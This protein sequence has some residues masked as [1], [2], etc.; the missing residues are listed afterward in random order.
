MKRIEIDCNIVE[1]EVPTTNTPTNATMRENVASPVEIKVIKKTPGQKSPRKALLIGGLCLLVLAIGGAAAYYF[2]YI[3]PSQ[4]RVLLST[5]VGAKSPSLF[6]FQALN[7]PSAT[8]PRDKEN[9]IN[10]ELYTAKQMNSMKSRFP[11]AVMIENHFAA[12]PQSCYNKADLVYETLA[13]GGITR[14]MAFFWGHKCDKIG[15]VRSARQYFIE[16]LMPFDPL[17]MHIGYAATTDPR[18][19]AGGSLHTYNI[20]TL[21]KGG[22]F[23]RDHSRYAP[24][25]AYTSTDLLYKMA[26][27]YGY[28]GKP[29]EIT[30]W[31]FKRDLPIDQRG[32]GPNVSM[33]FYDRLR[34]GGIYDISWKYDRTKNIYYRYN[35][36]TPYLDASTGEK[37]YAHNLIIERVKMVP[38]YDNHA[39]VIITTTGQGN[40]IILRDGLVLEGT[41]KKTGKRART[42]YYDKDGNEIEFNRGVTWIEAVPKDQGNVVIAK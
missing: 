40:A 37:V 9:P 33:Y 24:H 1:K 5:R 41:W 22:T 17:Y 21:N 25:N 13:E 36:T 4:N 30:P 8:A 6:Q 35:K 27:L 38:A 29:I 18:T 31:K 42:M 7:I 3:K 15:P 10:G 23:W 39:H 2:F 14:T 32:K 16:W 28:T 26:P 34:N 19:N 11:I 12:R 20:K